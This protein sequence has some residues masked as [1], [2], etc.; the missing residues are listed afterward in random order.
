M[1]GAPRA[2]PLSGDAIMTTPTPSAAQLA[3]AWRMINACIASYQIHPAGWIP[4]GPQPPVLRTI[5]GPDSAYFYDVVPLYQDAVGFTATAEQGYA[6][7][8][9]STGEDEDDA[10]LVG[11]MDDG[12]LV[13]ALRGTIPPSFDNDDFWAWVHD[14]WQDGEMEP[15]GWSV[16]R[17]PWVNS[18]QVQT[19]FA[20]AARSLW[21][22]VAA[23]MQQV[24]AQI[25]CSGVVITGH[26]K[27]GALCFLFATL[28]QAAFPQFQGKIE[29]HAFAAPAVGNDAFCAFYGS[30]N[31]RTHR[32]QVEND[33]VPFL[34]FWKDADIFSAAHFSDPVVEA[35][36][37]ALGAD[38]WVRTAGGYNAVGDFT[39][40]AGGTL[41]PGADVDSSALPAVA[42][43]LENG[44][45]S[46]IPDAHSAVASYRPC[47][48]PYA[49]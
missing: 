14:W 16:A 5:Q 48:V 2:S 19:G 23:M 36:W 30:L 41:V 47:F 46:A 11:A 33:I 32:Y 6:P 3:M 38:F 1:T 49:P 12:N 45:L 17:G 13:V 37:W 4:Y 22:K 24:L 9:V 21:P 28:V 31:D 35:G 27:G 40:F 18:I 7:L 20:A 42:C 15:T 43:T 26:S 44:P 10:A 34:P 25:P 39:Y 29:V 8:F